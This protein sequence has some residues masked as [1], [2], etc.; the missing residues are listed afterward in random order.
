M[1]GAAERGGWAALVHFD[2]FTDKELV[3]LFGQAISEI[4][5]RGVER[6]GD[7]PIA[8]IAEQLVAAHYGGRVAPPNEPSYGADEQD[9]V[10]ALLPDE[11][12]G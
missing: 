8:D 5:D 9:A 10:D 11:P 6:S 1:N 4:R 7:K 3:G 12:V 2:P